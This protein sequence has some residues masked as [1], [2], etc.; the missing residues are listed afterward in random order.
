M[1]FRIIRLNFPRPSPTINL[2]LSPTLGL[3]SSRHIKIVRM[4]IFAFLKEMWRAEVMEVPKS[5]SVDAI[6]ECKFTCNKAEDPDTF[7]RKIKTS[8]SQWEVSSSQCDPVRAELVRVYQLTNR[9]STRPARTAFSTYQLPTR[10][11]TDR[12]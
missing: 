10:Q 12:G 8:L 1:H 6:D 5:C 11:P 4:N 9:V 7:V 2:T 3:M